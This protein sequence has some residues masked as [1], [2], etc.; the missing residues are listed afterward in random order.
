MYRYG[1]VLLLLLMTSNINAQVY[2]DPP[3]AFEVMQAQHK[4][5]LLV[6]QGSDWCIPCINLEH[7]VL[8]QPDFLSF[9]KENLIV[10]KADFP[11]QKQLQ[12]SLVKQYEALAEQFD[13]EGAFPKMLLLD[14]NKKVLRVFPTTYAAPSQLV[15]DLEKELKKYHAEM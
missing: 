1:I 12:A 3:A 9:V 8:S 7:R 2:T 15:T 11:Q 6:F 4:P 10:L 13:P 14:R 5:M